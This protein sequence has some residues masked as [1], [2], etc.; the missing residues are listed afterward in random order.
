MRTSIVVEEHGIDPF[1]T[2]TSASRRCPCRCTYNV[3]SLHELFERDKRLLRAIFLI[4][5]LL[6][7]DIGQKVLY[8]FKLFSTWIHELFHGIAAL[9]VGGSIRWLNIYPN[10]SGLAFTSIPD[11]DFQRAFVAS[12][13]YQGTSIVGC[14][15]LMFRRNARG[16]RIGNIGI[17]VIMLLTCA[18]YVRNTFGLSILILMGLTLTIAG[19]KLPRFLNGELYALL[20]ATCCLN[21]IT[22][23][24][25]LLT[26]QKQTIGGVMRSSDAMTMENVTG[27]PNKVFAFLWISLAIIMSALGVFIV[28]E[29]SEDQTETSR[30]SSDEE[31]VPEDQGLI[32]A[33]IPP[34][35]RT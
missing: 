33:E 4:I 31:D 2:S 8:P 23:A 16:A 35:A 15:M 34:W 25:V 9:L 18:L 22:S 11:G 6:N 21:A 30:I 29:S 19:L 28:V 12:S 5:I 32:S 20:A 7:F 13:G 27:I 3:P 1:V 26:V 17:G 10:G 14:I 24:K